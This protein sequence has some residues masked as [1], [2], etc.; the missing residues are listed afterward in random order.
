MPASLNAHQMRV[1]ISDLS[2]RQRQG[3]VIHYRH[4]KVDR[5]VSELFHED[6]GLPLLHPPRHRGHGVGQDPLD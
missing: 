2:S 4:L 6:P 3:S 5:A 1:L